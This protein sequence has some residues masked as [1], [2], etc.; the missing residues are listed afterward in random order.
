MKGCQHFTPGPQRS[1]S[2]KPAPIAVCRF[3]VLPGLFPMQVK[4]RMRIVLQ[5]EREPFH[6]GDEICFVSL[7]A[8]F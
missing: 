4:L 2:C 5:V 7:G 6:V 8:G 3:N 1:Y